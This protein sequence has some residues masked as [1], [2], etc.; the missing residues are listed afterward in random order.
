MTLHWNAKAL[1]DLVRLH[2]F[3]F[4]KSE[5]AAEKVYADLVAAPE[6]LL[7]DPA[8]GERL[9]RFHPREVR[10]SIVGGLYELWYERRGRRIVI[11]RVWS[12][13]ENR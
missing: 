3:L 8:I 5:Q 7:E 10:R 13:R 4:P 6:R 1:A 12:T 2:A 9:T 11:L